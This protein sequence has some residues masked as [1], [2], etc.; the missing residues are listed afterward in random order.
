MLRLHALIPALRQNVLPSRKWMLFGSIVVIAVVC[1]RS[2]SIV[3]MEK[4]TATRVSHA[5]TRIHTPV[6]LIIFRSSNKVSHV[7]IPHITHLVLLRV[8]DIVH[9]FIYYFWPDII[10]DQWEWS[11]LNEYSLYFTRSTSNAKTHHYW[12]QD[13]SYTTIISIVLLVFNA[14]LQTSCFC[15]QF[16]SDVHVLC[17]SLSS[18]IISY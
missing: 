15:L 14:T 8:N 12:F 9:N 18:T 2:P 17:R 10:G 7:L 13:E 4:L 3:R 6:S 11:K 5:I 1:S 16:T